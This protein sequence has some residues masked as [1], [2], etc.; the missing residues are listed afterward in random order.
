MNA[1][2]HYHV[3]IIGAGVG[4]LTAGAFLSRCGLRVAVI[5]KE[6][7]PGGYLAGFQRKGFRFDTAIHWLNQCGEKGFVATIFKL[8]GSDHPVFKPQKKIQ[9]YKGDTIDFLLTNSPDDLKKAFIQKFPEDK[10]GIV[11]FFNASYRIG[12]SFSNFRDIFRSAEMMRP[13]EKLKYALKKLQFALPFIPFIGYDGN[14]MQKGLDKYFS[15]KQ[16]HK[17]FSAETD[18]LSCM[19]PIGWAYYND[20]QSP[21]EGG[22]QVIP[23]WLCHIVKFYGNNIYYN[24]TVEGIL[25]E[26]GIAMGVTFNQKGKPQQLACDYLIA[27]CDL[28]TVYEQLLPHGMVA[29]SKINKL[30]N[31]DIYASSFTVS[32]ALDCPTEAL[33]FGEEMVHLFREDIPK[34]QHNCGDPDVSALTILAPS[35]KDKSLAPRGMGTL[36][37]FMPAYMHQYNN[38]ETGPGL[39][40]GEAYNTLKNNIAEKLINRIAQNLAPEI[41][42]HIVFYEAATPVTHWRY[43]GNKNGTMMGAKP[44][45]KNMQTGVAAYKTPLKNVFIGGHWAEL[46]GGVP[47]AVK[48]GTNA[49]LMILQKQNP[50]AFKKIVALLEGRVKPGKLNLSDIF[51]PYDNSWKRRKTMAEKSF[52][53]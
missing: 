27:A 7:H 37:L 25:A 12:K 11:K 23:E 36:V 28:E 53:E 21:P 41:K 26:K 52:N 2:P 45:R 15:N 34:E 20:Y 44:G 47:I 16:L 46:G 38:W 17:I 6:P 42:K 50:Q 9:R 10:E 30:H 31:A 13:P 48:A 4:G 22:G 24:A 51:R 32:I 43:T 5:E 3:V 1:A 29:E 40:R 8:L 19:V 33:G 35:V 39:M 14:K 49:A 18:L